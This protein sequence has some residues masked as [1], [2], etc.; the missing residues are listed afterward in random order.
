MRLIQDGPG[1]HE[2]KKQASPAEFPDAFSRMVKKYGDVYFWKKG[3]FHVVTKAG[4]ARKALTDPALSCDRSPFFLSRM[5]NLDLNL[6]QDFLAVVSKMMVMSDDLVHEA[7]RMTAT[8]GLSD[9]LLDRYRH[10]IPGLIENLIEKGREGNGIDFAEEVA[11]HIPSTVLADLFQIPESD[12]PQF[13]DWSG[14][15]TGFF[16]GGSG[17]ENTDGI[18][19]NHAATQLKSYFKDLLK[20][21]EKKPL[22]D[23]FSGM[24]RVAQRFGLDED[25]LISQAVMLLVAGQVT[26]SDQM[27]NVLF[28]LLQHPAVQTQVRKDRKELPAMIEE[29][30]RLDPAVTFLFRV[31]RTDTKIGEQE[32]KKGETVFLASHC[33]NRDLEEFPDPDSVSLSRSN[34][35]RHFTYGFGAHHCLGARLAR[36]E[37]LHVFETLLTRFSWIELDPQKPVARDHYSLSFSGFKTLPIILRD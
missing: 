8:H 34:L 23:F 9:A 13:Y 18:R 25:E 28:L 11:K 37:L 5:P 35:L 27:N 15:M 36:M 32:V 1:F 7:R 29:F 3:N 6:I 10:R 17:Y 4:L 31:A 33:I 12:R 26:T 20:Q 24:I 14:T 2:F 16:G 30:S 21:R 22:D 19:V